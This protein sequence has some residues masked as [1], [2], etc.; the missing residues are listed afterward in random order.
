MYQNM[1]KSGL[2]SA[3]ISGRGWI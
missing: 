2:I 1:L 3:A